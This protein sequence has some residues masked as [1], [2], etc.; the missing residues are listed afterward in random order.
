MGNI[1]IDGNGNA[2]ISGNKALEVTSAIDSNI[3][4]GNIK[5]NVS[6]LGVTGTYEGS[7]GGGVAGTTFY[8][9]STTPPGA[10]GARPPVEPGI[11]VT[12]YVQYDNNNNK[13][14]DMF[15]VY[16][17]DRTFTSGNLNYIILSQGQ[18]I[19]DA[20]Y[21]SSAGNRV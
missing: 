11:S 13:I 5:K 1:L 21:S 15:I 2:L 9:C 8:N 19:N 16:D 17:E 10:K 6:I 18:P 3:V 4:P 7:G 12:L 14:P 20:Y